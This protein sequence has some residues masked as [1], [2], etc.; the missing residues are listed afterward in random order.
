MHTRRLL[1]SLLSVPLVA[2]SLLAGGMPPASAAPEARGDIVSDDPVNWTPHVTDGQVLSVIQVGDRIVL[3]GT[4]SS[5]HNDRRN[6]PSTTPV[7]R[8]N[9]LAFDA[10]TGVIDPNFAPD[11]NGTVRVVLP[12][13]DG[14]TI[15]V[16]GSFTEIAGQPVKN[17]ARVRLSDGS[18]VESFNGGA[19]TGAV[20][21]LRLSGGRLW[22]AGSFTHVH[23]K[24]QPALATLN[25]Q[26]GA[27]DDYM[28]MTIAGV[29]N[30]GYTGVAKIDV[31][32]AGTRLIG[33]GNFDT[34]D[35]VK[36]HQF[37][38]I[39]I[40]G[41]SAAPSGFRTQFYTTP[42]SSS[43]DSYM[44][45]LD[46]SPDG[47]FFVVTTTGAYGGSTV[48]CDTSARFE[49]DATGSDVRPSWIATTG[50]DTT[51]AVEVTDAV[52]YTGG[53]ARWQNNPFGSD[54]PGQGAVERPG[55][56]A[57]DPENGLPYSW[58]PTRTRGVGVFDMLATED[59]LWVVSDTDRI[60]SYEYHARVAMLPYAGGKAIVSTPTPELPNH[61][62]SI[63]SLGQI[64]R[65]TV[66]GTSLSSTTQVRGM[67]LSWVG[68]KG[69]FMI[70]G[71]LYVGWSGGS[72]TRQTYD[73]ASG[74]GTQYQVNTADQ[75]T[76]LSDWDTDVRNMTAMFYDQG[77]IYFTRSGSNQLHY[78]Y[79]NPES[80]VV[81]ALRLNTDTA[82]PGLNAANVRGMFLGGDKLYV[83][84]SDGR[85]YRY[86]WERSGRSGNAV[87]TRQTVA[88]SG[89]SS[90][91]TLFLF[92][93]PEGKGAVFPPSAAF[94]A[95]CADEVCEFDASA[96]TAPG[97]SIDAYAW[98]FGDGTS[99]TGV[100][101]EHAYAQSGTYTV[102]L[103]VTTSAG[104]T[105]T[106][107]KTLTVH[108][109]NKAPVADLAVECAE[110]E[111]RFDASGSSDPDGQIASVQWD[112][113]D[114]T[115]AVDEVVEH[116]YAEA[117]TY[118]VTLTV[119][120]D[121]GASTTETREVTVDRTKVDLVDAASTNGNRTNHPVV[122][123][124]STEAGDL[125]VAFM[126]TNSTA[127]TITGPDGWTEV[128]T[129]EI[130]GLI[131]STWSRRATEADAGS[132]ARFTTS[133]TVKSDLTV[134]VY[135]STAGEARI[136]QIVSTEMPRSSTTY[137]TSGVEVTQAGSQVAHYW[138]TKSSSDI[139]LQ[140][141]EGLLVR[142]SSAGSGGGRV[143]ALLA[144]HGGALPVG[145]VAPVSASSEIAATRAVAVSVVVAPS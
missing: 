37:L 58:N 13:A 141:P 114:G 67:N 63:R 62:Y 111:C 137:E 99:G 120:D 21:D 69:A 115:A 68:T 84:Y 45:D 51:Y 142:A 8:A 96:T 122:V 123:P 94:D 26:T 12:A 10:K 71:Q 24:R 6:D 79:F 143:A 116:A 1:V 56:A 60:G 7:P 126:T 5:A 31:D 134:A 38:M 35:G 129:E 93:N 23:G 29:H 70:N 127:A 22:V 15:Y 42:C 108:K 9:I 102:K 85:L 130:D 25:P 97:A 39:D 73:G 135:R 28:R 65:R 81:G 86:D 133:G 50:G 61:L 89:W 19:P 52:V 2:A 40:T 76:N 139:V 125:L 87:G 48:A 119:T 128:D 59:G 4:F 66:D 27:F 49:T 20:R 91:G 44:R 3:G 80:D 101:A 36:N 106:T 117:G 124:S 83:A 72:F 118:E 105:A 14:E 103:T 57:L 18:V 55:I 82:L 47:S 64:Q 16:G 74:L 136:S 17:L 46:F 41:P 88:T 34:L 112:L 98:D 100:T 32:P 53:H 138:G 54:R 145:A 109:P 107:S 75:L 92:Q 132:T 33:V 140:A 11:T 77:R 121:A 30:G 110:L 43:F 78:R 113:G 104:A 144:D 95:S 90:P 131:V